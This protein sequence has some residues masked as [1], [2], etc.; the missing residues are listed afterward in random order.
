MLNTLEEIFGGMHDMQERTVHMY[1]GA[2]GMEMVSQAFAISNATDYIEWAL[3]KNK[4]PK[5]TGE[6]LLEM[7]KSPDKENANLAILALEQMTHEHS[8]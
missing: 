6:S 7:L 4:I 8:I 3:E 5:D 2:H 1:V